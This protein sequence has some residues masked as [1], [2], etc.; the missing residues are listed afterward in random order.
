MTPR[1]G[2]LVCASCNPD[3]AAARGVFDT[4]EAGEGLGLLV[5]RPQTWSGEWLAGSIPGWTL[6]GL[7]EADYQSR[8]L[9]NSG[10]LFFDGADALGPQ[11]TAPARE[12]QIDGKPAEVGVENVYEYEPQGIG[13]CQQPAGCVALISSG[14]SQHESAFLD[15]SESGDDVFF[16]DRRATGRRRTPTTATTSTTRASAAPQ[17]PAPA[18]PVKPAPPPECTGEGC[19]PASP[20][21]PVFQ[22][23]RARPS[24]DPRARPSKEVQSRQEDEPDRQNADA[25][26]DSS[27][28]RCTR[29]AN[30]T[31]TR[32]SGARNCER[33][34]RKT[35]ATATSTKT[36][37]R[38]PRRSAGKPDKAERAR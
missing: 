19:R 4:E 2:R 36:T 25:R 5:D 22:H 10:R 29:A 20:G 6:I 9:S 7:T 16:T 23:L 8:Y 35:Y 32:A 38:A 24:P 28:K 3:G 13:S 21:E 26:A 17:K 15:A 37:A 31:A 14:T 11:V 33:H 18:C 27:P 34:A 12:E 1:S 30:A